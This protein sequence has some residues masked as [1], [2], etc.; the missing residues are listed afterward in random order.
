MAALPLFFA[1]R[2]HE[3]IARPLFNSRALA[4]HGAAFVRSGFAMRKLW[5]NED[6]PGEW[7]LQLRTLWI[8]PDVDFSF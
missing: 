3:A 4:N 6:L 7:T 2:R 5:S 8:T 1:G